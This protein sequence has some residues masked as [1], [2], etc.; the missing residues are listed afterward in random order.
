MRGQL[1]LGS[2]HAVGEGPAAAGA[3]LQ[4]AA[5]AQR[6]PGG[7]QR[8]GDGRRPL[9]VPGGQRGLIFQE[10]RRGPAARPAR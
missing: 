3:Q 1:R 5:A 2:L 4:A 8:L 6:R 7:Q 10:Q 9:P